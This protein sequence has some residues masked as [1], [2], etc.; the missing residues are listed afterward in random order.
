MWIGIESPVRC[1]STVKPQKKKATFREFSEFHQL[2]L[3]NDTLEL[4]LKYGGLPYLMHLPK[5]DPVIFDYLKNIHTTILYRDILSR[6]EIRDVGFL[7]NLPFNNFHIFSL[8]NHFAEINNIFIILKINIKLN[9][10]IPKPS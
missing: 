3:S 5:E 2:A 4:Y 1:R 7:S 10:N 9:I 6:Y 8:M